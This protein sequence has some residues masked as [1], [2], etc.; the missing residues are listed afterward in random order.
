MSEVSLE[1]NSDFEVSASG[2]LV[3]TSGNKEARQRLQRR[4]FTAVA[5][6]I[7]HPEYGAGLPQRIGDPWSPQYIQA[8]VSSQ[9]VMESSVA[10]YPPPQTSAN[11]VIPGMISIDIAYTSA[12]TGVAVN[13]TIS[14]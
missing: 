3:L 4:L 2:G 14:G 11:E 10:S 13:F 1:W 7:W 5:G 12:V 8:I 9:V 6:Y